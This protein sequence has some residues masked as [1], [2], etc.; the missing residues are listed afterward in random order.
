MQILSPFIV[1]VIQAMTICYTG[2]EYV[3]VLSIFT[4]EKRFGYPASKRFAQVRSI[5]S[6]GRAVRVQWSNT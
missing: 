4:G 3:L 5:E 1:D 6:L 2:N